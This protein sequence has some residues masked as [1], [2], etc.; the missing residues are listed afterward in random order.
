MT[1]PKRR[2]HDELTRALIRQNQELLKFIESTIPVAEDSAFVPTAFQQ[3]ILKALDGKAL[4]TDA[5]AAKVGDRRRL[6]KDPGG[7]PEL[8]EHGLVSHNRRVGYYRPDSLP[9]ELTQAVDG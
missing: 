7:L 5:L 3:D 6:F 4:R 2:S 9:P 8:Q 1:E